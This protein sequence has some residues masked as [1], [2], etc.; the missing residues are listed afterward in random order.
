[1]KKLYKQFSNL[2]IDEDIDEMEVSE[3][4]RARTKKAV[5]KRKKRPHMLRNITAAAMLLVVSTV[6]LGVAF[7]TIAA[8]LPLIGDIYALFNDDNKQFDDYHANSSDIGIVSES[9]GVQ[10]TLTNAV[11]DGE[12]VTIAYLIE[13]ELDLGEMPFLDGDYIVEGYEESYKPASAET[14][15]LN[16]NQ[17]AGVFMIHL[18]EGEPADTINVS[19]NVDSILILEDQDRTNSIVGDWSFQFKLDAIENETRLVDLKTEEKGI[20][21]HVSKMT[22]SPISTVIHFSHEAD[23]SI[24]EEWDIVS[25]DILVSDN[26]GNEY[27]VMPNAGYGSSPYVMNWRVTTSVFPKEATSITI[28]PQVSVTNDPK[29]EIETFTIEPIEIPL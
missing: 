18:M 10:V 8:Q 4:E 28:T 26:L 13:S 17:Y 12:S 6:T 29:V 27:K 24:R 14:E 7:P 23:S 5:M 1:M 15:K 11:Y 3:L 21:V 25:L 16:D 2:K 22:Q 20:M 19:Y 9:N